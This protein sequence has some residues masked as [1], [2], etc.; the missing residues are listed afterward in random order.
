MEELKLWFYFQEVDRINQELKAELDKL[1]MCISDVLRPREE[2]N[3]TGNVFKMRNLMSQMYRETA[4]AKVH[5]V[6]SLICHAFTCYVLLSRRYMCPFVR[7]NS[8]IE[9]EA[10]RIPQKL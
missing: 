2:C 5:Q 10:S 9:S 6:P 1:H 8:I 7:R 3:E 4:K